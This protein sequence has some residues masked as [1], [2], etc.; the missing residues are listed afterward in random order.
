[1]STP[2]TTVRRLEWQG[3]KLFA[4]TQSGIADILD[5]GCGNGLLSHY[6]NENGYASEG[7]DTG[8]IAE[9]GRDCGLPILR[10]KP[11]GKTKKYDL[12]FAIEVIEHIANPLKLFRE[13]RSLLRPGGIAFVTTGN[14]MPQWNKLMKWEYFIPEIHI[15]LFTPNSLKLVFEKSGF[16]AVEHK[17]SD[18]FENIVLYKILKNLYFRDLNWKS[19]LLTKMLRPLCKIINKKYG[20]S[21]IP[22]GVAK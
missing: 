20:V 8:C 21:A 2:A 6:L 18:I 14:A 22:F 9:K 15:S 3:L 4:D 13:F 19:L 11:T 10:E 17:Y 12:I 16:T 7:W 5:Y 1:M